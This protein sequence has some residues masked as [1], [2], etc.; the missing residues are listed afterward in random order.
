MAGDDMA[1]IYLSLSPLGHAYLLIK[2]L[3][4]YNMMP[5]SKVAVESYV[6]LPLFHSFEKCP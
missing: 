6:L 4:T 3:N 1:E 2:P 5:Y